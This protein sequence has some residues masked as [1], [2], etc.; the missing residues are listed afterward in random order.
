MITI[1]LIPAARA[2]AGYSRL[3]VPQSPRLLNVTADADW[4]LRCARHGSRRG[5][6]RRLRTAGELG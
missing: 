3:D 5:D 1:P 2:A 6:G 4:N